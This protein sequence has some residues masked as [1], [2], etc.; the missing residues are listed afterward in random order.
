MSTVLEAALL[1]LWGALS[2]SAIFAHKSLSNQLLYQLSYTSI[3]T[4]SII[5]AKVTP[6]V[7]YYFS[8]TPS[9]FLKLFG[10]EICPVMC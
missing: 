9:F 5:I 1:S 2:D 8:K 4:G 7:N 6:F 10:V 3:F